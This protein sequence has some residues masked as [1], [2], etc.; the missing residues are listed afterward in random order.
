MVFFLIIVVKCIVRELGKKN[1]IEVLFFKGI[2]NWR[3]KNYLRI[4]YYSKEKKDLFLKNIEWR[5]LNGIRVIIVIFCIVAS[6][7]CFRCVWKRRGIF[8]NLFFFYVL[9]NRFLFINVFYIV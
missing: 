6:V 5:D 2:F 8:L 1:I 4:L 9:F 3:G 7:L